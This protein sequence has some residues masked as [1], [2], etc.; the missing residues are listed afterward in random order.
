[1]QSE[2]F[3]RILKPYDA[4]W[5]ILM[6]SDVIWSILEHSYALWSLLMHSEAFCSNLKHFEAFW[7]LK[8]SDAFWM[9]ESCKIRAICNL[10]YQIRAR[11]IQNTYNPYSELLW[12]HGNHVKHSQ[13]TIWTT[14]DMW[15]PCKLVA[16]RNLESKESDLWSILT[17]S[18]CW[19]HAKYAQ[20]A[21]WITKNV[22]EPSKIHTIPILNY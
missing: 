1:M 21:I 20:S 6:Q 22:R 9:L 3:W 8:H 7:T 12:K 15:E 17:H 11:T 10:D 13:S 2:A 5:R 16:N 14:Q 19:S 4:F 18:E